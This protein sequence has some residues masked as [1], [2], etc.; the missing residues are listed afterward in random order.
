MGA[1]NPRKSAAGKNITTMSVL[2]LD[3]LL[4]K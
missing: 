1:D 4:K 2:Q 3:V